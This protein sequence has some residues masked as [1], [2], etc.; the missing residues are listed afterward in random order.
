MSG[1]SFDYL[2]SKDLIDGRGL[3]ERMRDE[4]HRRGYHD[5]A[6]RTADVLAVFDR[7]EVLQE[8]LRDLWQE[9]EWCCSCDTTAEDVA[10]AVEK[11]RTT[12]RPAPP[13]RVDV[14]KRLYD[15]EQEAARLRREMSDD[16]PG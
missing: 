14:A 10:V 9:V 15:L 4:L 12:G 5:A 1:G 6:L 7:V 8:E 3:V 2:Y 16:E 11:W 13:E